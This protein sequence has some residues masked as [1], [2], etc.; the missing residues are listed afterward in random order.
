MELPTRRQIVEKVRGQGMKIAAVLPIHYPRALLRAYGFHPM[1]IWGPPGWSEHESVGHFPEYTC[2]IVRNATAF[3]SGAGGEA[4]DCILL[5][6]TCDSLQGMGSILNGYIDTHR[7]VLTLY[8][9]RETSQAAE[10]FLANELERLAGELRRYSDIDPAESDLH[11]A[12]DRENEADRL[13]NQMC[14]NRNDYAVDDQ[15]FYSALRSREY[16]PIDDFLAINLP[17]GAAPNGVPIM[18]SGIVPE[19]MELFSHLT[20][21]GARVVADDLAC[22]GRRVYQSIDDS[23]PFMRMARQLLSKPPDPTAGH[24][25]SQRIDHMINR[26]EQCGAKGLIV[27]NVK[28]CEPELFFLPL[29]TKALEEHGWPT[30]YIEEELPN[31]APNQILTRIEAFLEVL[32]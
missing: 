14:L 16:L 24:L 30:L 28:F 32:N 7:P 21:Y 17:E 31:V 13:F 2:A 29:Q 20:A 25:V 18:L 15:T 8:N 26:M 11:R 19:P 6:H 23:N 22:A 4:A 9:P 1:E 10:T 12:I 27:M 3:L 5:P